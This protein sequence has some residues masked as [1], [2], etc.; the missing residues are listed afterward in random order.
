MQARQV[1]C[2]Y[3]HC[4]QLFPPPENCWELMCLRDQDGIDEDRVQN[5]EAEWYLPLSYTESFLLIDT[6]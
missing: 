4:C 2:A 5:V 6:I 3:A 1:N